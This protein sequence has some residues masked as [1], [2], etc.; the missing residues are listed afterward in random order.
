MSWQ[1]CVAPCQRWRYAGVTDAAL[2]V[3]VVVPTDKIAHPAARRVQ[4][5]KA[6]R[7]ELRFHHSVAQQFT[8]GS[9]NI[10]TGGTIGGPPMRTLYPV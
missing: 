3:L 1:L 10:H 7:L 8:L 6:I 4:I 5:G 9:Q 2:A